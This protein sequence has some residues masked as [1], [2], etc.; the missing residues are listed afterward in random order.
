MKFKG[1]ELAGLAKG[2][3]TLNRASGPIEITITAL[4][5]GTEGKPRELFPSPVPPTIVLTTKNGRAIIGPDG[6]VVKEANYEDYDYLTIASR[7]ANLQMTYL[8]YQ[9]IK[10]DEQLEFSTRIEDCKDEKEFYSKLYDEF[11]AAGFTLGDIR[12]IQKE[13]LALSNI[14][15]EAIEERIEDFLSEAPNRAQILANLN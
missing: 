3:V 1:N 2:T 6:R 4:A 11:A 12:I 15:A 5:L 14:D 8:V 7:A 9:C 13:I 10:D